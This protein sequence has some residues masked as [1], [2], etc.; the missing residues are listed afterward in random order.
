[1][2]QEGLDPSNAET[3]NGLKDVWNSIGLSEEKQQEELNSLDEKIK[4][5]YQETL[6][7]ARE[8]KEKC[9]IDLMNRQMEI[10]VISVH[11]GEPK[12]EVH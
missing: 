12:P 3:I 5:L 8:R 6:E 11:L 7:N 1:M 2:A 10:S 9:A 4:K